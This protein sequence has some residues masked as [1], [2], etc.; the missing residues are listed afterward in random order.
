MR[1]AKAINSELAMYGSSK[2]T[3]ARVLAGTQQQHGGGMAGVCPDG[4]CG[5]RDAGGD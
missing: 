5:H 2:L 1:E 3:I 4:S